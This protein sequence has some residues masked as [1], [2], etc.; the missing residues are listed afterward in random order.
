MRR[1]YAVA[2]RKVDPATDP[3]AFQ[4]LR[5]AYE[6][7][8]AW[9]EQMDTTVATSGET[10]VDG[11]A[12]T[13]GGAADKPSPDESPSLPVDYTVTL[14]WRF[15]A[16][17]GA[18]RAESI[19]RMLDDILA[20][21]RTQ[22]I[23]APGQ[24]EEHLIDLVGLQRIAHRAEVFAA[25]ETRF[26]WNEV[27]HLAALRQRGQWV[28]VVLSQREAWL[29]LPA[30]RRRTWLELF[31]QAEARL[32]SAVLR[33]WPEIAKLNERFPAWLGLHLAG[34]TLQAWRAGF[35]A[36]AAAAPKRSYRRV[37]WCAAA[38]LA[39]VSVGGLASIT[40]SDL[41]RSPSLSPMPFLSVS[42]QG[43]TLN[44]CMEL[45]TE[46][47]KPDAFA[48][49]RP[50]EVDALK[51]RAHRCQRAG[52]WHEQTSPSSSLSDTAQ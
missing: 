43:D 31:A 38:I 27:G 25:A 12:L 22:Y 8:R 17:V 47:D 2:V 23:D 24:F 29:T 48:G 50:D 39:V 33:Y 28:G 42:S 35:D 45:Y 13:A 41:L 11:S 40:V 34:E 4:R 7:A 16:D 10:P 15:A 5:Q 20:E 36:Q 44:R 18:H 26:H 19:P 51:T 9:C 6:A 21:L 46:L 49:K 32:D 14:A 37:G 1:A 3:D 30:D 52:R